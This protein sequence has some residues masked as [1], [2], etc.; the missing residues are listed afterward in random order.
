MVPGPIGSLQAWGGRI[1]RLSQEIVSLAGE[2]VWC[3]ALLAHY[4]H[5]ETELSGCL[6]R[7]CP[8]WENVSGRVTR[9][10]ETISRIECEGKD[11]QILL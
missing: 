11:T 4:R 9:Q 2:S 1:I 3:N 6:R 7:L 5:G 10:M 8:G